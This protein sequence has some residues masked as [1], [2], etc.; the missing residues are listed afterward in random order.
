MD[1]T[2][3]RKNSDEEVAMEGPGSEYFVATKIFC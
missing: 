1:W 3:L 2:L